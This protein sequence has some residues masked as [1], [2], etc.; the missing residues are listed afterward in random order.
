MEKNK[1]H[2]KMM[3]IRHKGLAKDTSEQRDN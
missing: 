1:K 3:K 2:E